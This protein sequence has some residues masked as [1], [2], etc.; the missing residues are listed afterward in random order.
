M[1]F[2]P[3]CDSMSSISGQPIFNNYE[4]M[5]S[6][7]LVKRVPGNNHNGGLETTVEVNGN[8]RIPWF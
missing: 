6:W 8:N 4:L 2:E 7:A 5:E 1:D 3:F